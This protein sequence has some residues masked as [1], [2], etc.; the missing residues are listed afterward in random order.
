MFNGGE[1]RY[2]RVVAGNMESV[3]SFKSKI[4]IIVDNQ[5]IQILEG[6]MVEG[7]F[8]KGF[9]SIFVCYSFLKGCLGSK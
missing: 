4:C 3:G 2:G 5:K 8:F 6:S 1:G 7:F 9:F